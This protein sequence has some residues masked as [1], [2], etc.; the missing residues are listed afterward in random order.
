MYDSACKEFGEPISIF[1][2]GGN[3]LPEKASFDQD[4]ESIKWEQ[5]L[6]DGRKKIA[7]LTFEGTLD[8][9]VNIVYGLK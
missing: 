3:D 7:E 6:P 2:S 5:N 4:L 9:R 8:N 1:H